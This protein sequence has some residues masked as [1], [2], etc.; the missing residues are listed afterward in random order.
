MKLKLLGKNLELTEA[1]KD[2][3]ENKL[4]KIDRYFDNEVEA[5]AVFSTQKGDHTV[6]ITVFLPGTILRSE[7]TTNDMYMSIDGAVDGLERQ[8]RKY[9][10]RLKR[11]YKNN[12]ETIRFENIEDLELG[13]NKEDDEPKIV[14]RKEL[15]LRP[16]LE[17]E[18]VL[19]MEL[20]NHNFFIFLND[21]TQ[22]VEVLYKRSDG[23]YGLIK[24][25]VED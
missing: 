17:E 12:P 9:K 2:Q 3:A 13:A 15:N 18:A 5:R 14:K 6:E 16:M 24:V 22:D 7:E 1:L 23:D 19:Q 11:K 25:Y 20:L 8:I 21:K 10:T 4:S